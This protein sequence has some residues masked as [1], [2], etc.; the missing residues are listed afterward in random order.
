MRTKP[1]DVLT[2]LKTQGPTPLVELQRVFDLS[3]KDATTELER[4]EKLGKTKR[5][6][7]AGAVFW[8]G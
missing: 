4:L 3:P 1:T 2:Y 8:S 6:T 7:L 5:L